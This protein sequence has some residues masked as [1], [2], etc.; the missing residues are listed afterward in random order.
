MRTLKRTRFQVVMSR[1]GGMLSAAPLLSPL[2]PLCIVL[3]DDNNK[4]LSVF[5]LLHDDIDDTLLF[6]SQLVPVVP[7]ESHLFI[8]HS[9]R[10]PI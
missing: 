7:E 9:K 10:R 3:S 6:D 8:R 1:M 4:S 2:L 5:D